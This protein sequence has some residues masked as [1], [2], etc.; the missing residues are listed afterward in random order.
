MPSAFPPALERLIKNLS[1]LPGIGEKTATRLALHILRWPKELAGEL[2]ESIDVLHDR[3]QLCSS[4]YTFSEQDPCPVCSDPK[5]EPSTICVVEEPGDL[6]AMEK[7]RVFRGVYH[8]LHGV[9]SPMDGIGPEQ[10]KINELLAR[11]DSALNNELKE[12]IIATSSTAA[13][14]ATAAYLAELLSRKGIKTSRIACGIP[15]GMDLKYADRM[16]LQR[17]IEARTS[18][19]SKE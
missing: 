3:I 5:R 9:I 15:M 19:S 14:E 2:A 11:V 7:T 12:I 16:T 10:L 8:V 4:C 13:G 18:C 1:R 6:L 17:A